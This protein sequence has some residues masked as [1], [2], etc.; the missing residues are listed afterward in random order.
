MLIVPAIEKNPI[1]SMDAKRRRVV[2]ISNPDGVRIAGGAGRHLGA[3]IAY[4]CLV[5]FWP[6]VSLPTNSLV[7]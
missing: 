7:K 6:S 2:L 3:R 5:P 1:I 4:L